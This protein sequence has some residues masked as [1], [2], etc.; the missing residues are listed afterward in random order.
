[1]TDAHTDL[2]AAR[3]ADVVDGPRPW[4]FA[5]RVSRLVVDPERF[6]DEREVMNAVGMGAVYTRTST[7]E[8]L[9]DDNPEKRASLISTVFDPYA[10]ALAGLVDARID[11]T[12]TAVILDIHSY[13]REPLPYELFAQE[14][15]PE[16]CLGC[17]KDHTPSWL[18]A[19]AHDALAH[20]WDVGVNGPFRGTY[21]PLRH[22]KRDSRVMSLMLEIRRDIYLRADG[23]GV[24]VGSWS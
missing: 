19:L 1:M 5:N 21:V 11:V 18:R 23:V 20:H 6:P 3:A 2:I 13:P 15:R 7:G 17:D 8:P 24:H 22:Y 10:E 9:R 12:G 16:I 14:A 4:I